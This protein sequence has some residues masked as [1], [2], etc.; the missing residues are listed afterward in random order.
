MSLNIAKGNMYSF[1][2]HTFNTIK[3]RCPHD[4]EYCY[5]KVFKLG[6]L[7]VDRREFKT[8]LG[9]DNFIFVGS[10]CDMFAEAIPDYWIKETLEYLKKFDNRYLFQSKNPT[11]FWNWYSKFP[12]KRVL[13]TTIET[14]RRYSQMGNTPSPKDRAAALRHLSV[15]LVEK[16]MVTIEPVMDF[17][18]VEL[19][20]L[21]TQ[22]EPEWVNVGADSKGHNLPEP[23]YHKIDKLI[24]E[25]ELVTEV[26]I[27]PNL[28]RIWR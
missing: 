1:V 14:N 24:K 20:A 17:D 7:Y 28:K 6:Q 26:K 13:G 15:N 2:T 10:S 23:T 21:I 8:D 16:T 22:I 9:K 4:C 19:V 18:L 25:L 11:R 5:M 12:L 3:G 27:K